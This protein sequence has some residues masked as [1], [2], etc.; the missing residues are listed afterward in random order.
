MKCKVLDEV[1]KIFVH[2]LHLS[3]KGKPSLRIMLSLSTH[4][5]LAA[6]MLDN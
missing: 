2:E 5:T 1:L 3:L 4:L 6:A